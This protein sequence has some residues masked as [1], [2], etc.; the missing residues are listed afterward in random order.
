[1]E[2]LKNNLPKTFTEFGEKCGALSAKSI[3]H[4]KEQKPKVK[5]VLNKIYNACKIPA[6][7]HE[8]IDLTLEVLVYVSLIFMTKC[9]VLI[10][11]STIWLTMLPFFLAYLSYRAYILNA[12][13]KV[14][15]I[16]AEFIKEFICE[17]LD[18]L[19]KA[20]RIFVIHFQIGYQKFNDNIPKPKIAI[21]K[22]YFKEQNS[23]PAEETIPAPEK[24]EEES[25]SVNQEKLI[26]NKKIESMI[27]E[28]AQEENITSKAEILEKAKTEEVADKKND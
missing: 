11:L 3:F 27:K 21:L 6:S 14:I 20:C 9:G 2:F 26:F 10:L 28:F 18:D 24:K 22:N 1:M 23:S 15:Q 17:I 12:S 25:K 19:F 13:G 4:L 8:F 16:D 7:Y 5:I